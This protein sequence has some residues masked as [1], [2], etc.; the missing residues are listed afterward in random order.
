MANAVNPTIFRAYDI[1]GV[2][3]VDLSETVYGALGRAAGTYFRRRN[4]GKD[5]PTRVVVGRDARLTSPAYAAAWE[6]VLEHERRLVGVVGR[7][8]RRETI[9]SEWQLEPGGRSGRFLFYVYG[10][11]EWPRVRITCRVEDGQVV[12][13][14]AIEDFTFTGP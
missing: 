10:P 2:V 8:L 6:A 11:D 3:D 9:P 13:M 7:P 5:G 1:R 12:E 14:R 4:S